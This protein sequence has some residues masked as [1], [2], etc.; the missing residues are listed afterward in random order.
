MVT[1]VSARR[2][3]DVPAVA[4]ADAHACA[5]RLRRLDGEGLAVPLHLAVLPA[6]RRLRAL[7][8]ALHGLG[9]AHRPQ[10]ARPGDRTSSGSTT[11]PRCSTTR[12]SGTRSRTRSAIWRDRD[13]AAAPARARPRARAEHEAA[14]PHVLPD[15][16]AAAADHLARRGRA[17]LH[18]ALRA[19]LRPGQ[20]RARRLVGIDQIDWEAGRSRPGSRSR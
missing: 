2:A 1:D 19:R 9:L 17:D 16:R 5:W 20:L 18:A 7:P 3:V 4:R 11:T 12:T 6:L 13:G 15:G 8:A 14:R 10:P